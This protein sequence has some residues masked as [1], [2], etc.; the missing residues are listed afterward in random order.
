MRFFSSL[1]PLSPRQW[2]QE[3][4]SVSFHHSGDV[5]YTSVEA[6]LNI[7]WINEWMTKVCTEWNW[8]RIVND[9]NVTDYVV[10]LNIRNKQLRNKI[11]QKS[12]TKE[13]KRIILLHLATSD[14]SK[15][16]SIEWMNIIQIKLKWKNR[17][18]SKGERKKVKCVLKRNPYHS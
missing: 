5:Q 16:I 15:C 11:F 8:N 9:G 7:D 6:C 2:S 17:F 3:E 10:Q 14:L 1:C 4:K 13:K 18:N 12:E